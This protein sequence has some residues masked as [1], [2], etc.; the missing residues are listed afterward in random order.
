LAGRA[1]RYSDHCNRWQGQLN[2]QLLCYLLFVLVD[3]PLFSIYTLSSST[4]SR[5][6]SANDNENDNASHRHLPPPTPSTSTLRPP[7]GPKSSTFKGQRLVDDLASVGGGGRSGSGNDVYIRKDGKLVRRVKKRNSGADSVGSSGGSSYASASSY[8]SFDSNDDFSIASQDVYY[9][10][11]GKKVRRVKKKKN[12]TPAT[13]E[14]VVVAANSQLPEASMAPSRQPEPVA[15]P[16]QPPVPVAATREVS[17]D[18]EPQPYSASA[19]RSMPVADH[20]PYSVPAPTAPVAKEPVPDNEPL[21]PA[22]KTM[23]E[24]EPISVPPPFVDEEPEPVI[25]FESDDRGSKAD[26]KG[27][28]M[29]PYEAY[30]LSSSVDSDQM[31]PNLDRVLSSDA[32]PEPCVSMTYTQE[33]EMDVRPTYSAEQYMKLAYSVSGD[34]SVDFE[35]LEQRNNA[36]Q[37]ATSNPDPALLAA[38]LKAV[39]SISQPTAPTVV[40][41]TSDNPWLLDPVLSG[42]TPTPT[43]A[44]FDHFTEFSSTQSPAVAVQPQ[45]QLGARP[46][47]ADQPKVLQKAPTEDDV[48]RALSGA[49]YV[50]LASTAGT[51]AASKT[52]MSVNL[53]AREPVSPLDSPAKPATGATEKQQ[54]SVRAPSKEAA[55]ERAS[56]KRGYIPPQISTDPSQSYTTSYTGGSTEGGDSMTQSPESRR[57]ATSYTSDSQTQSSPSR[58]GTQS[59]TSASESHD[60]ESSRPSL[61]VQEALSA[62]TRSRMAD[63]TGPG[64]MNP[65]DP[66]EYV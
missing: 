6:L 62:R 37:L 55:R 30:L 19:A 26:Q 18:E 10:A 58:R 23:E 1:A 51:G 66:S 40:T 4:M 29:N 43:M 49:A 50:A 31:K 14:Q 25:S 47:Y 7:V 32:E 20:E 22:E 36:K 5:N 11:D 39:A 12:K 27:L 3:S 42:E 28:P 54:I 16:Q 13:A 48:V 35:E 24:D 57:V 60:S 9:R 33:S 44:R 17:A 53:A 64:N 38:S 52:P 15:V 2:L 34:P 46:P 61:N 45:H 63:T 8:A 65:Y 21:P 59:Y 41:E 56:K